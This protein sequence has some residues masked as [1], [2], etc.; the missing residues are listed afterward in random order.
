MAITVEL[1]EMAAELL[2]LRNAFF[3]NIGEPGQEEREAELRQYL[4]ENKTGICAMLGNRRA[5]FKLTEIAPGLGKAHKESLARLFGRMYAGWDRG[6]N[7]DGP[8][9]GF[10]ETPM[11]PMELEARYVAAEVG[12]N[13]FEIAN[14]AAFAPIIVYNLIQKYLGPVFDAQRAEIEY[15]RDQ[16]LKCH[17]PSDGRFT[18]AVCI[19]RGT[20]GCCCGLKLRPQAHKAG[21]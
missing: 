6:V 3:D 15:L 4:W 10:R 14:H 8:D 5:P 12:L 7:M 1:D 16:M 13:I 2:R 19:E 9:T 20:C 11:T 17:C 21:E 18:V